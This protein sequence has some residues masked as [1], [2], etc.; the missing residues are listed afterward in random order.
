MLYVVYRYIRIYILYLYTAAAAAA[1]RIY[2][3]MR[4]VHIMYISR[5]I[6]C[7]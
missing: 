4:Y 3:Y 7:V 2:V 6:C 1:E 5:I